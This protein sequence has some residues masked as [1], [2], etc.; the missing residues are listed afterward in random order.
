MQ[1]P[2][3]ILSQTYTKPRIF[4]CETDKTKICLLETANTN[5]TF[6]FNGLSELSFEV[7]RTYNDNFT[8]ETLVNPYYNK[9]ESPRLIFVKGFGYFEIQSVN[10]TSDG[11]KECKNITAY[12]AEYVLS[13]KYLENFYVNTGEIGSVEVTYAED[14]HKDVQPVVLYN[15][16]IPGL[17]LLH[18]VLEGVYGWEIGEVDLELQKVSRSFEVD[19]ESVYDFIMNEICDKFNCYIVFNTETNKIDVHAEALT[20]SYR[21]DGKRTVFTL[22]PPF[23]TIGSVSLDGY[24]V[25]KSQWGYDGN[26]GILVFNTPPKDHQLI[27][28][29]DGAFT[30]SETDVLVSFENLSQEMSVDYNTDDIKT[31]LTVKGAD[32][33]DIREV[34]MG[35]EYIADFSYYCTPDWFGQDLYDAYM[36]YLIACESKQEEYNSN[37]KKI[38]EFGNDILYLQNR[39]SSKETEIVVVQQN[40]TTDTVGTYF[41]RGGTAPNY[42]Y[43]EVKLPE[44]Y[45]EWQTYYLFEGE[46]YSVFESG[47]QDLCTALE[48]Y[49]R[50]YFVN[51]TIKVDQFD[52]VKSQF[53]FVEADFN[54]LVNALKS[55]DVFESAV[56]MTAKQP[57]MD[58]TSN[59]DFRFACVNRFLQIIWRELGSFPL[60]FCYLEPYHKV[61]TTQ[62]TDGF[63]DPKSNEYG[64]YLTTLL[65]VKS[66]EKELDVRNQEIAAK[67][68]DRDNVVKANGEIAKALNLAT[69]FTAKYGALKCKQFMTRLSAFWREDE[70]VDDNFVQTGY[71][72]I[73]EL[74]QLKMELAECGKVELDK[75]CRPKL[76]FSAT[77]ANIYAL[78]EFKP[79]IDQF[80]LGKVIKVALRRDYMKQAR[81]L[82]VSLNFDD[83]SDFAAEFG[84]LSDLKT[85]S[86]IHA[87][88]L[89]KAISAGKSVAS[90]ESYWNKGANQASDIDLRIQRGLLDAATSIKSMDAN[91]GVEIDSYGIHLRAQDKNG[92]VLPEQGW[93]T[94]NK[95]LFSNDGFQTVKS[96]YGKYNID[97]EEYWGVLAEA[98]IA[99]YIEGS[100]M[101]GGTIQI[102]HQADGSYAFEVREDGSV[103][104][105]G[106]SSISGY[107][108]SD[109]LKSATATAPIIGTT[110]PA[111][112]NEGQIWLDTSTDPPTMMVYSYGGWAYFAQQEGGRV[113][114]SQPSKYEAGDIWILAYG[115]TYGNYAHGS[116]LKADENLQ[117]TDTTPLLTQMMAN[118]DQYFE[119]NK[120]TGL[121]IGQKDEK[122]HVNITSQKMGFNE[123]DTEVVSISNKSAQIDNLTVEYGFVADCDTTLKGDMTM[124]KS[125]NNKTYNYIWQ[126]EENGSYSLVVDTY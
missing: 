91:Q 125:I 17:S 100:K 124:Q 82:Q 10:L 2:Y 108:T 29:T 19:R 8:G 27:E 21:G 25:S 122:F 80:Q 63:G 105:G 76:Q 116:I 53:K 6:K 71:E 94:N 117:W 73:D 101:R 26:T 111:N 93:I 87:D 113:Y 59:Q 84:E 97:N 31:V 96:V 119:F 35:M 69:Y 57:P 51:K 68:K 92:N 30:R 39:V 47:V 49:F 28:V 4:L 1:L 90:N 42:Y 75:C 55:I 99:G 72:S 13:T 24:K 121:K 3:D 79:I 61:Q 64:N 34:N 109:E 5:A 98:V 37:A 70:Y 66:I 23:K 89:A 95:F 50:E 67:Q 36:E 41:V 86:D 7:A 38:N 43:S 18:L 114:T 102:G 14:N 11:I 77:M 22:N 9:I 62:V 120:N 81:L 107:A 103:T 33:L 40:V 54:N 115:E 83:L 110:Q 56:D 46:G 123:G 15:Q 52:D 44:S 32:E 118:V 12:S 45:K 78:P 85:Q 58:S 60:E 16:N 20:V 126:L 104:M 48:E 88:L 65:I 74:Y 106:G 112:A